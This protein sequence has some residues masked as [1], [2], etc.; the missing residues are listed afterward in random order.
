MNY[1]FRKLLISLF[2]FFVI[3]YNAI[4]QKSDTTNV[5]SKN[6]KIGFATPFVYLG[7][8][9]GASAYVDLNLIT[10]IQI[11]E[12]LNLGFSGKYQYY[13]LGGSPSTGFNTNI[14]GGS[15]FLQ[16]AV[17]KDFRNII[18]KIKTKKKL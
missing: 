7:L 18:K 16:T 6:S 3:Q 8:S 1:F 11:T 5:Q 10:G 4:A 15:V 14:Y 17:I 13:S 12:R 9:V 2:L